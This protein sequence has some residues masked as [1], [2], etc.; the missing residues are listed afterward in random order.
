MKI[1]WIKS[2]DDKDNFKFVEKMGFEVTKNTARKDFDYNLNHSF[3]TISLNINENDKI[4]EEHFLMDTT[5]IRFFTKDKCKHQTNTKY[6]YN[7]FLHKKLHYN[8]Y[9]IVMEFH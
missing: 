2:S 3:G 5:Y 1:S 7:Y 8:L 6:V 4:N 9:N